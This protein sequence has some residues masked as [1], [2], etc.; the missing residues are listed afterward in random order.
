MNSFLANKQQLFLE[1]TSNAS[2]QAWVGAHIRREF[3]RLICGIIWCDQAGQLKIFALPNISATPYDSFFVYPEV[4]FV[5]LR[6]G[7]QQGWKHVGFFSSRSPGKP[8]TPEG[9][10][11]IYP[12]TLIW[13]ISTNAEGEASAY[14]VYDANSNYSSVSPILS[15]A[16]KQNE[17]FA[18]QSRIISNC[19]QIANQELMAWLR[20]HPD[21]LLRVHPGTFELIVAEIFRDQGYEV[22]V[23][24]SWNESDGGI[25]VI[26]IRKDTLVGDFRVGIQCKRYVKMET[27]RAD[28][29][30]ALN[31]RLD[32]FHLHKGV[33]ATTAKF[34]KSVLLDLDTHLWRI[35]LRDFDRMKK[36]LEL[37]GQFERGATGLWLPR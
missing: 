31:G 19:V 4:L 1:F 35:E 25:D 3:P 20:K 26:A 16:T 9:L 10:Q 30:W 11:F 34:E 5:N 36:D 8:A 2:V 33:I 29:I 14:G 32:K 21:D 12:D 37:W 24:G 7:R 13:L 22:E 18:E 15:F 17:T 23:L 27:V 28:L 6:N